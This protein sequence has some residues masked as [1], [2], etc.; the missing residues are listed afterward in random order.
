MKTKMQRIGE[1]M[2]EMSYIGPDHL[3]IALEF[4]AERDKQKQKHLYLG[5]MMVSDGF[6][7]TSQLR[8]AIEEQ[9][10][11]NKVK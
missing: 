7:T 4:Q 9:A 10:R 8:K 11:R 6:V 5:E 2:M 1:I 3:E